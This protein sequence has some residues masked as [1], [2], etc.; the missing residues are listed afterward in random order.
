MNGRMYDPVISRVLS[1]DNFVQNPD[2]AQNY[3]RYSYCLNNPLKFTD[4]SGMLIDW[5]QNSQG[6]VMWTD[7][8]NKK[9]FENSRIDGT[10]LGKTHTDL[11]GNYYSLFGNKMKANSNNGKIT[12]KIDE[13]FINYADFLEKSQKLGHSYGGEPQTVR[14]KATDFS[15]I[16]SFNDN[17][18]TTRENIYGPEELGKYAN[19]ADIYFRVTGNNMSGKFDSF[20]NGYK[21]SKLIGYNNDYSLSGNLLNITSYTG[22]RDN[23]IVTLRFN[24]EQ[25]VRDFSNKFFKLFPNTR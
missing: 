11:E 2:N 1:P 4:P 25:S 9:D 3:N 20:S 15:G 22:K 17:F 23:Q 24:S 13:T 10:Y 21:K 12:Q 5:Y 7:I 14:E 19:V 6:E 8:T 16:F 18:F